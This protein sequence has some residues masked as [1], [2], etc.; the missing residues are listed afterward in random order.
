M[1]ARLAEWDRTSAP[2]HRHGLSVTCAKWNISA[3]PYLGT[4]GEMYIS[5][6]IMLN[7]WSFPEHIQTDLQL[8][9]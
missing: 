4:A 9:S 1:K 3:A 5:A 6:V 7:L 2:V 8:Y